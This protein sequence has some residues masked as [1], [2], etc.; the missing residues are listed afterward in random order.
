MEEK[1]VSRA[2]IAPT[3]TNEE[4]H[5]ESEDDM[6]DNSHGN[7]D[8]NYSTHDPFE[9]DDSSE[10]DG[11]DTLGA[12]KTPAKRTTSRAAKKSTAKKTK[13]KPSTK[14][15]NNKGT[16]ESDGFEAAMTKLVH[17]TI[18]R[19]KRKEAGGAGIADLAEQFN[20]TSAAL[21]SKIKAAHVYPKFAM[22]LTNEE[23]EELDLYKIA[24]GDNL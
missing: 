7:D 21:G 4:L 11:E 2:G 10:S 17:D 1:F 23:K 18:R 22:F 19:N 12:F 15:K 20:R 6:F 24:E 14:G 5:D 9:I 16:T 13:K 3:V 8:G